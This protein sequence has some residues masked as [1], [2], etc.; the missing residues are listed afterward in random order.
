MSGFRRCTVRSYELDFLREIKTDIRPFRDADAAMLCEIFYRSV[1]EVASAKYSSEQ[2]DAWAPTIPDPASWLERLQQYDTFVAENDRSK[3]IAWISMSP[4]GYIDMLF[5]LPEAT[6]G[7]VAT[8]LYLAVERAA[9]SRSI[10]RLTAHASLL[11]QPFFVKHGWLV[12]NHET[13][14]RNGVTIPRAEMSKQLTR[15][16]SC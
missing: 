15:T 8:Q 5:C 3:I 9:L 1:H 13:I 10:A 2:L 7:G 12:D 11:A 6:G 16:N 4:A 14:V